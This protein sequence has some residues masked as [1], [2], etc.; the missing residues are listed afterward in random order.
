[1]LYGG[2]VRSLEDSVFLQE[3]GF[4]FGEV[5]I[6]KDKPGDYWR[7]SGITNIR[8]SDFVYIA[9]GPFEGPPNDIK[10]LWNTYC[11]ALRDTV[12]VAQSLGI[13]FLTVH[14]WLDSRFIKPEII[15]EKKRAL[16]EL[17]DYGRENQVFIS[18]ENL[19]ES[20]EDLSVILDAIP[21]LGITLDVGH[22]QLLTTHNTSFEIIDKL[23]THIKHLHFHDNRG[24]NGVDDD[25]HL[26]IGEGIID[27]E[28]ILNVLLRNAYKGT[29]TLELEREDLIASRAKVKSMVNASLLS[30]PMRYQR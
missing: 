4:E 29:L 30:L 14:M 28:A 24:G 19:S 13:E 12:N 23:M 1:M 26:P 22:A 3:S 18:L 11:P 2:H 8:S 15:N 10:N 21:E 5:I 17:F 16:S 27:F 9:H 7:N 6:R 20:V 25:L